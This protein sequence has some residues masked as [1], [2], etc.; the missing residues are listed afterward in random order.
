MYILYHYS[1]HIVDIDK[2]LVMAFDLMVFP[3]LCKLS[4]AGFSL[5]RLCSCGCKITAQ[6][7]CQLSENV[8]VDLNC[9]LYTQHCFVDA[10]VIF[11]KK[12][13]SNQIFSSIY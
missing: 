12:K 10:C 6:S 4:I 9:L 3:S 7:L 1:F 8:L 5:M 13:N 2:E 11:I